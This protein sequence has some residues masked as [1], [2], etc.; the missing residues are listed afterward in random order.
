MMATLRT[1]A[2]LEACLAAGN[3]RHRVQSRALATIGTLLRQGL[4]DKGLREAL[5]A[6]LDAL[7]VL[8]ADIDA[9]AQRACAAIEAKLY[10]DEDPD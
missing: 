5:Q 10:P 3:D 7:P 1:K 8:L 4:G 9:Q 2:T 6:E